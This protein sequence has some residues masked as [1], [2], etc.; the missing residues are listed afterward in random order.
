MISTPSMSILP[1]VA[2]SSPAIKPKSV[3]FPLPDGPMIATNCRDG[4][5]KLMSRMIST[6]RAP[7]RIVLTKFRTAIMIRF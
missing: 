4:T 5:S 3:L 7:F 6:A 1:E 2:S